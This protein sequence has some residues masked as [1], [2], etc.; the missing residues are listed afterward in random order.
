MIAYY[1]EGG[2]NGESKTWHKFESDREMIRSFR[3]KYGP[4]K[5]WR[6][7]PDRTL[8]L[9]V[10]DRKTKGWLDRPRIVG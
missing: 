8:T 10:D 5:V 7:N 9:I 2:H 3:Y 6:E 1:F 4:L